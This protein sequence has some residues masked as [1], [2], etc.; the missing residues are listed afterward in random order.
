MADATGKVIFAGLAANLLVATS[1]YVAAFITG[2]SSMLSEA[3][4]STADCLNQVLLFY[5]MHRARKRPTQ[6]HP[7][8][9]GREIYFWSFIVAL[10]IF[11]LGAG[12]SVYEG[13]THILHP[14]V[15]ESFAVSY[16]VLGVAIVLEGVS[17]SVAFKEFRR[18]KGARGWLQAAEETK[19]PRTLMMFSEDTAALMGL[20][21]A[22][23]GTAAAQ[24]TGNP[25]WDGMAS[26]VIGV[27]LAIVALFL[28]RENKKL[29][30]GESARPALMTA[31][32][33]ATREAA[34]VEE[35]NGL[36]SFQ[37]SPDE[38]VVV[39]SVHFTPTMHAVEVE[40]AIERLEAKIRGEHPEVVMLVVKPQSREA[41][42][43]VVR[44]RM[45]GH[46]P[47]ALSGSGAKGPAA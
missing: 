16:G 3:V 2:S 13:I 14:H 43:R 26:I 40:Q 1:K 35:L 17:W 32:E 7:L 33:E 18:R 12:V 39:L 25:F 37:L 34:A 24:V 22:L 45:R 21:V 41:Y 46:T 5:G 47:E 44:A 31:I 23:A 8:G 42:E 6:D 15:I 4:H 11:S 9:H 38:V 36:L 10:L 27:L 20:L 28:A 30:I 19:D 29:L